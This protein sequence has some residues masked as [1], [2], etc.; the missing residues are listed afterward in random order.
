MRWQGGSILAGIPADNQYRTQYVIHRGGIYRILLERV[1]SLPNVQVPTGARAVNLDFFEAF[2]TLED[3]RVLAGDVIV[4][5]DGIKS[6]VLCLVLGKGVQP[7]STGDCAYRLV[8]SREVLE[9]NTNLKELVDAPVGIRW[10]G[11]G[12]HA[13]A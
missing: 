6:T 7:V 3:G 8:L 12:R 2:V 4:G 11:P 10:V 1:K 5:A 9:S 13:M